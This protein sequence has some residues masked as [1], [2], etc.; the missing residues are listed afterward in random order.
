MA[1]LLVL[2]LLATACTTARSKTV[3]APRTPTTT[4]TTPTPFVTPSP[5]ANKIQF[6][7][8]T[9]QIAAGLPRSSADRGQPADLRVADGSTSR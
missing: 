6:S 2:T 4:A 5:V 8:C 3:P 1:L 9:T 7:D